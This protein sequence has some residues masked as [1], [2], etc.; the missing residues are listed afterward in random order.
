MDQPTHRLAVDVCKAT[1]DK[2]QGPVAQYFTDIIVEQDD[3]DVEDDVKEAH[4]LIIHL[5]KSCPALLNNVVPQLGEELQVDNV[6]LRKLATE[7]L[8]VM[9]AETGGV[10]L[11]QKYPQT[12]KQW[13]TRSRDK[14]VV[15]RVSFVEAL[16]NLLMQHNSL[17]VEVERMFLC[18]SSLLTLV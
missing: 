4:A 12:W 16:R 13:M 2:L 17:S 10:S 3:D 14:S 15:V 5:N 6:P 9:F 18:K 11:S 8:G 7:T 1:S